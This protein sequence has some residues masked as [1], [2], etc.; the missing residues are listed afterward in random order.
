MR[1]PAHPFV[2]ALATVVVLVAAAPGGAEVRIIT[3]PGISPPP[4]LEG[5][6]E[7]VAPPKPPAEPPAPIVERRLGPVVV[8]S[9][10]E[11][12]A[13]RL[14]IRL[15]GVEAVARDEVCRDAKGE[16]WACGRRALAAARRLVRLRPVACLVPSDARRGTYDAACTLAGEDLGRQFV[17]AGWARAT[18]GGPLVAAET[19]AR[20]A[21]R[22]VWGAA[23]V[24][25]ALPDLPAPSDALPPDL[26]TAPLADGAATR[27]GETPATPP[28]VIAPAPGR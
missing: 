1:S 2:P 24:V 25:A 12:R 13:G 8:E 20:E 7:R 15:P 3:G 21:G 23:P 11:I 5:P 26:T 10:A 27:P 19:E 18:A 17:A 6:P 14:R 16:D 4:V 22:G 9:A 28:T